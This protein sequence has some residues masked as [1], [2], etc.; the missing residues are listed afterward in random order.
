MLSITSLVVALLAGACW[1]AAIDSVA[2]RKI[3]YG[4][5][6]IAILIGAIAMSGWYVVK[7]VYR[8]EAFKPIPEHYN[9][10]TLPR[11]V[12]REVPEMEQAQ[13]A[14]GAERIAIEEWR[15]EFRRL[16]IVLDNADRLHI[17]TSNF[18]GWTAFVDGK[19][20]EIK[21]GD[22]GNIV[23]D[24]SPGEHQVALDFR[25]TPIRRASNWITFISIAFL[26]SLFVIAGRRR[27]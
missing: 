4:A 14:S 13:L 17:R 2:M 21:N 20:S 9:Y 25:S 6:S 26:I 27:R 11:G 7:P 22:V 18:P 5:A 8:G 23:I 15:P 12:P 3:V 19:R 1:R 24:L 10:A 16:R